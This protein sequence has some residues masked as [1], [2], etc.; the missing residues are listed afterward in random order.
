MSFTA[1]CGLESSK[2]NDYF[3][4]MCN[5]YLSRIQF[6]D[7]TSFEESNVLININNDN[8]WN[9]TRKQEEIIAWIFKHYNNSQYCK[10]YCIDRI[11]TTFLQVELELLQNG[12]SFIKLQ[13]LHQLLICSQFFN[14]ENKKLVKF[15]GNKFIENI[16]LNGNTFGFNKLLRTIPNDLLANI[17]MDNSD[18]D[19]PAFTA[20]LN[21]FFVSYEVNMLSDYQHFNILGN[22]YNVLPRYIANKL[23]VSLSVDEALVLLEKENTDIIHLLTKVKSAFGEIS[24]ELNNE[25]ISSCINECYL[26]LV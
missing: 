19:E 24:K 1:N 4:N 10:D 2:H 25:N 15:I 14:E 13:G 21:N 8:S 9:N 22:F 26:V 18:I 3:K 23:I 6:L 11:I 16:I 12:N 17:H 7:V 20:F 5:E